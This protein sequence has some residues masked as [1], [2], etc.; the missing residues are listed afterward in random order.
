MRNI[1]QLFYRLC[2]YRH[3]IK[4]KWQ[5]GFRGYSTR[6]AW[7]IDSWFEEIMPRILAELKNNLHGCPAEFTI[8][9]D[10]KKI[11]DVEKG[12]EE[13]KAILDRM[14]FCFKEMNEESCSLKNEFAKEYHKQ[15]F[16]NDFLEKLSI[17]EPMALNEADPELEQKYKQKQKEIYEYREK[18][19][20]EG[21][22]ILKTHFWNLWD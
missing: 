3:E 20:N 22:D 15:K 9:E 4:Y 5:R 10:G 1:H 21:F 14:I 6:D 18:M 11:Q 17:N 19:K 2:D 7:S 16:G 8:G 13:W 12:C